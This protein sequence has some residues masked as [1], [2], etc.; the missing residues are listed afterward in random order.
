M[1]FS[2]RYPWEDEPPSNGTPECAAAPAPAVVPQAAKP[3]GRRPAVGQTATASTA[4]S[5]DWLYHRLTISGPAEPVADFA[6][7]ARGAGVIPWRLDFARIEEDIFARAVAQPPETRHLSVAGCRILARQFRERVEI[8][9]AKA[10]ARV[11]HSL[12][13]PLDLHALL[14]VPDPIL[15]LGPTDPAA[16]AWLS[17]HW[18]VSAGLRQ[19]VLRA[20]ATAGRRL[21]AGDAVIGYG[22][23]TAGETPHEAIAQLRD[24]WPA[25]QFALVP[26]PAD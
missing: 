7:A 23:F 2:P 19:V 17:A 8:R 6:A 25:L 9:Q 24:R 1:E 22:F 11:G 14:P 13:C 18:G 20:R 3:R 5:P 15:A 12:A 16:F 10:C 21:P 26:R 4:G